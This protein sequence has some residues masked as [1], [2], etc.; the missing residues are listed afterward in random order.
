MNGR[1]SV[2]HR[3]FE[4]IK[5]LNESR[6]GVTRHELAQRF[7]ISEKTVQR[8]LT[9]LNETQFPVIMIYDNHTPR[10]RFL[11]QTDF[12]QETKNGTKL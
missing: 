6:Y 8:W 10:Y 12:S 9:S 1:N 2:I 4:F 5:I 7:E 11:K 3:A